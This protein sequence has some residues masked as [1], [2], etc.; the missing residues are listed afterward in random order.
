MGPA[1]RAPQQRDPEGAPCGW[2]LGKGSGG[3]GARCLLVVLAEQLSLSF[4]CVLS[5]DVGAASS[6]QR[7]RSLTS[8][9]LESA[10]GVFD[11]RIT[12]WVYCKC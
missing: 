4:F 1:P 11:V 7:S 3:H 6:C 12:G 8:V 2:P 9:Q 10:R 5:R